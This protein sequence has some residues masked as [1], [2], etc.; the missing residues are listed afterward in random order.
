MAS[1]ASWGGSLHRTA[2]LNLARYCA[3]VRLDPAFLDYYAAL[4]GIPWQITLERELMI[5][6]GMG[7]ALIALFGLVLAKCYDR[8]WLALYTLA[9]T[10]AVV[11]GFIMFLLSGMDV[12]CA[13]R[14]SVQTYLFARLIPIGAVGLIKE[15]SLFSYHLREENIHDCI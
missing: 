2:R 15:H 4:G 1:S 5:N 3:W 13:V 11:C 6:G 14:G 10:V 12:G 7:C 9:L 8:R